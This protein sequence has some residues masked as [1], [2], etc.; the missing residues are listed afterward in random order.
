VMFGGKEMTMDFVK[1]GLMPPTNQ[2]A[3]AGGAQPR[4][5]TQVAMA[6]VGQRTPGSLPQPAVHVVSP[7]GAGGTRTM[8]V[9]PSRLAAGVT[10]VTGPGSL[11]QS[12]GISAGAAAAVPAPPP[13]SPEQQVQ[14]IREQVSF[15]RQINFELP[16]VPPAPGLEDLSTPPALPPGGMPAFPV[17]PGPQ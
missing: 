7:S 2:L 12:E 13:L 6:N 17:P 10:G 3:V 16:P 15:S 9:R 11:S 4:P 1:D 5:G 8:P 14:L